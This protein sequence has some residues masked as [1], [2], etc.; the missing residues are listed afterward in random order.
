MNDIGLPVF[1][2]VFR[3]EFHYEAEKQPNNMM[4]AVSRP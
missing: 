4:E 1:E 3:G 2:Y